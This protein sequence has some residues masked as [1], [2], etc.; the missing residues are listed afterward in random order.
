MPNGEDLVA[1]EDD[2]DICGKHT[3]YDKVQLKDVIGDVTIVAEEYGPTGNT[4]R[5]ISL[6]ATP[7]IAMTITTAVAIKETGTDKMGIFVRRIAKW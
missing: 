4:S 7:A 1:N 3:P 6:A 2:E 5:E